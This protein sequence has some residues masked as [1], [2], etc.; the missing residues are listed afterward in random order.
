MANEQ[1]GVLFG[2]SSCIYRLNLR[3]IPRRILEA[4]GEEI[5]EEFWGDI[6]ADECLNMDG[7]VVIL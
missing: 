6:M 3:M 1:I 2:Q 7:E 5:S 4:K